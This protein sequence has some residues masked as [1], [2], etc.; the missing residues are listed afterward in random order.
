[1]EAQART[2]TGKKVGQLRRQGLVPVV[3]YGAK[4]DKPV[5][6]QINQ[7][8]LVTTLMKAG[9]THLIEL[10][11]D[12]AS[13]TV[14]ARDVQR[15]VLRGDILHVDFQAVDLT[16]TIT[17]TVPVHLVGESPA[18]DTRTG[19]LGQVVNSLTVEALP[20]NLIDSVQVDISGL[21][22]IGDAIHVRDIN[23][24]NKV[25]ILN[26]ADELVVHITAIV[27]PVEEETTE[28]PTSAEPQVIRRE[29]EED[30]E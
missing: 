15:D 13:H 9:G 26:D 19:A 14:L 3:V 20:A 18:V 24:G 6:L 11:V 22:E 10:N 4:M 25:T 21:K 29:R 8:A 7:R 28:A 1:L 30:E 17:A 16:Q 12:G 27:A 23:L 2:L 5:S